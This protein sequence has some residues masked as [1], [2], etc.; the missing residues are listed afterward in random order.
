VFALFDS[1]TDYVWLRPYV[2]SVV[3]FNHQTLSGTT[4][5]TLETSEN[6][7][8]Y[9]VFGGSELTFASMPRFG[10]SADVGYRKVPSS[11][12]GFEPSPLFVS[13]AGHWYVK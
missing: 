3:S 12:P 2:G 7:V 4:P 13:I 8:R 1:V 6:G 10:L 5:L 11:F 9:R